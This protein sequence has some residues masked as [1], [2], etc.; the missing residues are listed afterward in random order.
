[1]FEKNEKNKEIFERFEFI[2][3]KLDQLQD[4]ITANKRS[5]LE[6]KSQ[7]VAVPTEL[8]Q[9]VDELI[10]WKAKVTE[11]ALG[12]TPTGRDKMNKFGKRIFGGSH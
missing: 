2:S 1:M 6:L 7:S 12:R 3:K 10:L 8:K 5:I 11:M 4:E 9:N